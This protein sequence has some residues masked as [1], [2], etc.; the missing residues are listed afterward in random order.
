M[1]LHERLPVPPGDDLIEK[2]P[3]ALQQLL[4]P[5]D[6]RQDPPGRG[7]DEEPRRAHER[8]FLGRVEGRAARVVQH[9]VHHKNLG[10]ELAQ[11]PA[12]GPLLVGAVDRRSVKL[13]EARVD[14]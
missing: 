1:V 2:R 13:L 7:H 10:Q 9:A 4:G 5:L 6:E 12:E 3:G 8:Q 11:L 14:Q